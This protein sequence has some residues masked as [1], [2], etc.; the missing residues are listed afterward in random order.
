MHFAKNSQKCPVAACTSYEACKAGAELKRPL[1]VCFIY[2][3][4]YRSIPLCT[5]RFPVGFKY[6]ALGGG[7]GGSAVRKIYCTVL[8]H[9]SPK[10]SYGPWELMYIKLPMDL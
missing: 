4:M 8:P 1:N 7:G 3:F 6:A 5:L 2:I 9:S 10:S